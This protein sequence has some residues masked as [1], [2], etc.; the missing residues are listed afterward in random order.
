MPR[1]RQPPVR[2]REAAE[3][4]AGASAL[5]LGTAETAAANLICPRG[6]TDQPRVL[7]TTGAA[8]ISFVDTACNRAPYRRI[9][10]PGEFS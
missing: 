4:I 2:R 1:S 6:F 8:S 10:K 3:V 7:R 5:M 9:F